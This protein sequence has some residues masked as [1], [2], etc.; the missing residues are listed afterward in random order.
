[1]SGMTDFG[2]TNSIT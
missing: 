1:V 2:F